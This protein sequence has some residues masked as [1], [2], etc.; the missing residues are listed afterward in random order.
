MVAKVVVVG[1]NKRAIAIVCL[2]LPPSWRGMLCK[3]GC[4]DLHLDGSSPDSICST[5]TDCDLKLA[6]HPSNSQ[7]YSDMI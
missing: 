4:A 6:T 7:T 2:W 3:E 1:C 5:P